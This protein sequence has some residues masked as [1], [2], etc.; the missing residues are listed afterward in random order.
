MRNTIKSSIALA[1]A[2]ALAGCASGGGNRED[3]IG[4]TLPELLLCAPLMICGAKKPVASA[5]TS[6]SSSLGT[7]TAATAPAS[8]KSAVSAANQSASAASSTPGA[9]PVWTWA[10]ALGSSATTDS[11]NYFV[12]PYKL[13]TDG[14]VLGE[15]TTLF[16]GTTVGLTSDSSGELL[17]FS[18]QSQE[19]P[20]SGSKLPG[21]PGLAIA[22]GASSA[23]DLPSPFLDAGD[24]AILKLGGG[25]PPSMI[26][27]FA[28]PYRQGWSYQSFGVWNTQGAI[29]GEQHALSFGMLTPADAVPLGGAATYAGKL[30]GFYVSP[31]GQGSVA[32]ADIS[33]AVDFSARSLSFSSSGTTLTRDLSNASPAPTLDL[34]GTMTFQ[35]VGN[36]F[37]GT[38]QSAGG[39][40]SG[41]TLGGFYGPNAQE[42]SGEFGLNAPTTVESFVGAYGAKR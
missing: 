21:Q 23:D 31:G 33:V 41:Q 24:P 4:D 10:D 7:S 38:L 39:T 20:F 1:V 25:A 17:S 13:E 14:S 32:A 27:V 9:A 29:Y 12:T 37:R 5:G 26:A 30:A 2:A 35:P 28:N 16:L 34:R 40:I 18:H 11:E 19:I 36:G 3:V 22:V 8:S 6:G 15:R 42:L